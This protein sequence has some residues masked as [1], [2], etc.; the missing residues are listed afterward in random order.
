MQLFLWLKIVKNKLKKI[1][2]SFTHNIFYVQLNLKD[3]I[4]TMFRATNTKNIQDSHH[5]KAE[6]IESAKDYVIE[7]L[8][9]DKEWALFIVDEEN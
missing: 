8:N 1:N 7:N 2:T 3:F 5:F 4:M 6:S 9:N